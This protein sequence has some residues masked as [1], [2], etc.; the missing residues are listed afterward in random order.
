[1]ISVDF[2]NYALIHKINI[3]G[4]TLDIEFM[5]LD[6]NPCSRYKPEYHCSAH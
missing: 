2:Y 4:N 5:D 3:K 6:G 1:M